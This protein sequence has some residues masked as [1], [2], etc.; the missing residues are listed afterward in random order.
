MSGFFLAVEGVDGVGKSTLLAGLRSR[1][2]SKGREVIVVREPGGTPLGEAVRALLL[3]ESKVPIGAE[4]QMLLFLASRVQLW[5]EQI[6]PTLAKGAVVLSDRYHLST[7][8]YQGIAG[9]LGEERATE[10][11]QAVLKDRRPDLHVILELPEDEAARRRAARPSEEPDRFEEKR[12]FLEKVRAG[13]EQTTGLPGDRLERVSA[14][15]SPESVL[16]RVW[17]V[18]ERVAT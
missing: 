12:E 7:L 18:V 11:C 13:F 6:A 1:F 16:E 2:E 14:E 8:V 5:E 17:K 4:A 9:E 3:H 10:V 15:G